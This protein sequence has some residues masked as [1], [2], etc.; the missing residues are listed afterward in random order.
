MKL[1]L[2]TNATVVDMLLGLYL[3]DQKGGQN[4]AAVIVIKMMKDQTSPIM[5]KISLKKSRKR[6]HKK[7]Q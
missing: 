6:K 2:L 5:M 7:Q 3:T 4:R 1:E